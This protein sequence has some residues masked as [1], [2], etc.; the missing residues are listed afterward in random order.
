[1]DSV[2]AAAYCPHQNGG[3]AQPASHSEAAA[4]GSFSHQQQEPQPAEQNHGS[5]SHVFGVPLHIM[6]TTTP[7]IVALSNTHQVVSL[8]LTT[9]NYLYWRMQM[10]SYLLG[11]C[12]FHFVNGSV[13]CPPSHDSDCLDGFSSAINP[14]FLRWKQQDQLILSAL[15]SSLSMDVLHL[16]V[17]CLTSSCV[18]RTLEKALASPSNSRIMQLYG[19]FQDLQQGDASVTT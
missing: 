5:F 19:S 1:M 11:Q 15:L 18:R 6:G 13:S 16:V 3:A 12:V 4:T 2:A 8:K 10:K 7:D 17:D 9:T 14:S